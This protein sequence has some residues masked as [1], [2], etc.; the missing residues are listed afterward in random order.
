MNKSLTSSLS[1]ADVLSAEDDRYEA[2]IEGDI[3]ALDRLLGKDL[4]YFHSSTI[5]DTKDSF[6]KAIETEKLIYEEMERSDSRVRIYGD[7]AVITGRAQFKVVS[8]GRQKHLDMLFHSIWIMRDQRL[9]FIS[10]QATP[11]LD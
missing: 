1:V 10:W 7:I 2:Q 11:M 5:K 4:I 3:E 8:R 9:Q 6:I